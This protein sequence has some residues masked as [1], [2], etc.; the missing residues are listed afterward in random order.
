MPGGL[1]LHEA[2]IRDPNRVGLNEADD[3]GPM[4]KAKRSVAR[5]Y[6]VAFGKFYQTLE[7]LTICNKSLQTHG[8]I[9]GYLWKRNIYSEASRVV[10]WSISTR[11][12]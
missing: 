5:V 9:S 4:T 7:A 10:G 1:C 8:A 6:W 3:R 2:H 12:N 11:L